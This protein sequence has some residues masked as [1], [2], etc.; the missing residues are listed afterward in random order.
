M[1]STNINRG[2]QL[3]KETHGRLDQSGAEAIFCSS[4]KPCPDDYHCVRPESDRSGVC[5]PLPVLT[6]SSRE[7]K[8]QKLLVEF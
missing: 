8:R 1:L 4:S 2:E 3:R 7:E 6:D 5:C